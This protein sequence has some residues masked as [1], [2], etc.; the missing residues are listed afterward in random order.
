MCVGLVGKVLL[1]SSLYAPHPFFRT[2]MTSLL[3]LPQS[4]GHTSTH[5]DLSPSFILSLSLSLSLSRARARTHTHTHTHT[6]ILSCFC[7][8]SFYPSLRSRSYLLCRRKNRKS[9]RGRYTPIPTRTILAISN[10]CAQFSR[11]H[12]AWRTCTQKLQES[13]KKKGEKERYM[14]KSEKLS[15]LMGKGARDVPTKK[16]K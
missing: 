13:K 15:L 5:G 10:V 8:F 12:M 1:H 7:S 9:G 3:S 14:Q 16:K 11:A 6:H 2:S 4:S